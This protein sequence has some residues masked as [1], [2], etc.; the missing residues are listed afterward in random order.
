VKKNRLNRVNS[1]LQE[2]IFDVIQKQV[3]NPH[4]NLFVSI[5]R[6]ETSA[7]LHHAKVYIS[8]IGTEQEKENVVAALQTSAGFIAVQAS[9]Q[10]ELRHFPNLT[11][12]IDHAA[13]AHMKIETILSEIEKERQ[14]RTHEP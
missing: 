10:V 4:V 7:D 8:M 6:V 14:S 12:Y 13:D 3:G 2:V 1:L 9:K 11:F 5:S